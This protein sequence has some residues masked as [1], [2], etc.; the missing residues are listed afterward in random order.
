MR[1]SKKLLQYRFDEVC[2][3]YGLKTRKDVTLRD[4]KPEQKSYFS[5]DFIK[6]EYSSEYKGYSFTKVLKDTSESDAFFG[7]GYSILSINEAYRFLNGMIEGYR[8]MN[9]YK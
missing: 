2:K 4:V 3:L 8:I 1:T 7:T 9:N 6:M 5:D